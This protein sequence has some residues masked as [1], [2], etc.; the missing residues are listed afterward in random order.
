[1][2]HNKVITSNFDERTRYYLELLVYV[3]LG[4]D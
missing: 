3:T 1:M 4:S 2:C